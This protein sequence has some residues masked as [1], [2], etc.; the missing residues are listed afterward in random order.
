MPV[1]VSLEDMFAY[2]TLLTILLVVLVALPLLVYLILKLKKFKLPASKKKKKPEAP[3][4]YV[5]KRSI[6]EIKSDYLKQIDAIERKYKNNEIDDRE[7]YLE[8]STVVRSFVQ[9]MTGIKAVNLTLSE[10][11][12]L[13]LP[14]L[15][16]LIAEFYRP[17]FAY[18]S[19][20]TDT[21][22]HI[23]DARTVVTQWN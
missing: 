3:K 14:K 2:S 17:E 9:E 11:K 18:E 12:E 4:P 8:L 5:R 20:G 23:A 7:A 13:G 1:S 21:V 16:D 15:A 10:I 19:D 6:Q 22:R